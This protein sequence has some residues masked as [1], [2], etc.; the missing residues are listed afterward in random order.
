MEREPARPPIFH[1]EKDLRF[2]LRCPVF[3]PIRRLANPSLG[4]MIDKEVFENEGLGS[5]GKGETGT[6]YGINWYNESS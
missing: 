4:W 5:V 6:I 1:P 2:N 3:L